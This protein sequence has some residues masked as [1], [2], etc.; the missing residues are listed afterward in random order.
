MHYTATCFHVRTFCSQGQCC[1]YI[2]KHAAEKK[3]VTLVVGQPGC[4]VINQNITLEASRHWL[5]QQCSTCLYCTPPDCTA[6]TMSSTCHTFS[7]GHVF[8]LLVEPA[9]QMTGKLP[10]GPGG[11]AHRSVTHHY[12]WQGYAPNS[13]IWQN[14]CNEYPVLCISGDNCWSVSCCTRVQIVY[15]AFGRSER[16]I[17]LPRVKAV[18][19]VHPV[20]QNRR[21]GAACLVYCTVEHRVLG[22]VVVG[23]GI[24]GH[25]TE[26][27]SP[28]TT[29]SSTRLRRHIPKRCI[30][31]RCRP[32]TARNQVGYSY[33]LCF[34]SVLCRFWTHC[35]LRV[36]KHSLAFL[37]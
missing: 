4:Y 18:A 20:W 36:S 32:N 24:N 1:V 16:A 33:I 28:R 29:R 35:V 37:R 30:E 6:N 12:S 3:K 8:Q 34:S 26:K 11:A 22:H 5:P 9:N 21:G 17:K 25:A 15:F 2:L 14:I 13:Q 7:I 19:T 31:R 23:S 10:G 27:K